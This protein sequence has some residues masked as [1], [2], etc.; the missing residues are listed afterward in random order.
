MFES[1]ALSFGTAR[2]FLGKSGSGPVCSEEFVEGF[3]FIGGEADAGTSFGQ[4]AGVGVEFFQ[5]EQFEN[6][7]G[8]GETALFD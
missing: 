2:E 4:I 8:F 3:L 7:L 5:F 6:G 1:W